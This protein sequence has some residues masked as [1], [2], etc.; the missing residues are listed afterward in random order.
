MFFTVRYAKIISMKKDRKIIQTI[1]S[2]A[3][4]VL[5]TGC[6]QKSTV[7]YDTAFTYLEHGEPAEAVHNFQLSIENEGKT[8][9]TMRGL[10]IAFL[11]NEQYPQA[12]DSLLEALEMS[13]G[14]IREVDYDINDYLGY[15]YELNGDYDEAIDVYNALIMFKPKEMERYYHRAL[16]YLK[17][18]E[19]TLAN[20]D[21]AKV[22][23]K[24]PND[25]DAHIQI[26]FSIKNAGFE[27]DADSYLK[28]LL[29]DSDRKISDYDR[30]RLYYYI[31]NYSEAR[32]YLEKAKDNSDPNSILMLGKTY[33]AIEDYG[34]AASLYTSYLEKSTKASEAAVYNQLGVC[35][36]KDGDYESA[37][38]AFTAGLNLNDSEWKKEL[39][40]NE[41]VTYEYLLDFETA[42]EKFNEYLELYPKDENARHEELF[43]ATR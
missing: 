15:A 42:R 33:E 43:L 25:Y 8:K 40:F 20:E 5:L 12:I 27:L 30:G 39:L 26:Y 18:G 17:K 14:R 38:S 32:A 3:A 19:K 31:G 2:C 29:E 16:C 13:N 23:S 24:N 11:E 6:G 10:G 34:Y 37:L 21:F 4:I 36:W 9:D 1:L 41:A 7:Y 35:K 22:T 28:A